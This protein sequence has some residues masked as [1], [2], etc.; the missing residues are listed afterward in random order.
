MFRAFTSTKLFS[1]FGMFS[2]CARNLFIVALEYKVPLEQVENHL[3][4]HRAFLKECY[5]KNIFITSGR[6]EPR[7][8]GVII[9]STKDK[10]TLEEVLAKD[11]FKKNGIADYQITE[12]IPTMSNEAFAKVVEQ[13]HQIKNRPFK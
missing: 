13:D 3:E 7:T 4:A 2:Q 12:F 6:K 9:A 11:P 8:G 10:Q 1:N 5:A